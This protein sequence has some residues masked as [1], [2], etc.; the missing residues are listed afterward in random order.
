MA[1]SLVKPK[2][3]MADISSSVGSETVMG[4]SGTRRLTAS[5][6]A[7]V[8]EGEDD[9]NGKMYDSANDVMAFGNLLFGLL[10]HFDTE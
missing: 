10:V 4:G 3:T 7:R 6:A 1:C 9:K 5:R 8:V 2:A